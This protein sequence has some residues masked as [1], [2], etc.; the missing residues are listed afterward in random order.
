MKLG[1][2]ILK[3]RE[4]EHMS[5]EEFAQRY[6][7]TRQTISNWENEKNYPDLETLVKISEDSG[8]SIDYMLKDNIEIVQSIDKK[9]KHLKWFKLGTLAMV[10][11]GLI[12]L[13]YI[14]VQNHKQDILVKSFDTALTNLGFEKMGDNYSLLSGKTKFDVYMFE[15]PQGLGWNQNILDKDKCIVGTID[16][17]LNTVVT[18]RRDNK[19]ITLNI[20][21]NRSLNSDSALNE[22]SL[23]KNG[24]V[25]HKDNMTKEDLE[26]YGLLENDIKLSV[27][28]LNNMYTDIY[29]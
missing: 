5:Q 15:R 13:G 12:F 6:H 16:N 9:L 10:S 14:G 1:R 17:D 20:A 2:T 3:I 29:G 28:K 7:V 18:I 8:I 25:K 26:L 11:I 23:D 21:K 24:D 19:F 4:R 22:Y 27:K